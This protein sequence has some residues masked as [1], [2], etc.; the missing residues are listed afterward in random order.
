MPK[1]KRFICDFDRG[2]FEGASISISEVVEALSDDILS[3][4][5]DF[6]L[7]APQGSKWTWKI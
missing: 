7:F 5:T 1:L 2:S 3:M 6:L 4:V